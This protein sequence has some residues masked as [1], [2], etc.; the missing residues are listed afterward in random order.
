MGIWGTAV[1]VTGILWSLSTM[2]IVYAT[3]NLL[4]QGDWRQFILALL[5][6]I[7]FT[8]AEICFAALAE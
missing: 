5:V 6:W 4:I 2:F 3:V 1:A 7:A 8:T